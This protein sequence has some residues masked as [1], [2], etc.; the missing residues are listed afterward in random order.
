MLTSLN[1]QKYCSNGRKKIGNSLIKL[2]SI[3]RAWLCSN[4]AN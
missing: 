4:Y 3:L 1:K 2:V